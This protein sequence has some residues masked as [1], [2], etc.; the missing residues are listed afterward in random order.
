MTVLLPAQTGESDAG[1]FR[2]QD[3]SIR[4]PLKTVLGAWAQRRASLGRVAIF[5]RASA[6]LTGDCSGCGSSCSSGSCGNGID[7]NSAE[8]KQAEGVSALRNNE[9]MRVFSLALTAF[10][11]E[12][13]DPHLFQ[14]VRSVNSNPQKMEL[15]KTSIH[16]KFGEF[17]D[18]VMKWLALLWNNMDEIFAMI[19]LIALI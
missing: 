14:Y 2:R 12:R 13:N 1:I 15:L 16:E 3:G 10:A 8:C 9:K 6:A 11:G 5:P 7:C 19:K 4:R 17:P 18:T